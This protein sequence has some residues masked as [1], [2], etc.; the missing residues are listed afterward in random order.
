MMNKLMNFIVC[1]LSHLKTLKNESSGICLA[2]SS[3][4]GMGIKIEILCFHHFSFCPFPFH[5]PASF[6]SFILKGC[7]HFTFRSVTIIKSLVLC[8]GDIS[9]NH[10]ANINCRME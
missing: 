8:V 2:V 7:K 9:F 6:S 5:L 3:L 10:Y 1:E 4:M